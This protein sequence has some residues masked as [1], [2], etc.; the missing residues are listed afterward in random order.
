MTDKAYREWIQKQ[1]SCISG[2]F[3][4]RVDISAIHVMMR[5]ARALERCWLF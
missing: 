2:Q 3:S 5:K 4:G 1:P